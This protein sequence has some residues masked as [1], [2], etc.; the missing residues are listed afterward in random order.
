MDQLEQLYE[1]QLK[2]RLASFEKQRKAIKRLFLSAF[3]SFVLFVFV[4]PFLVAPNQVILWVFIIIG[5]LAALVFFGIGVVKF[6]TYRQQFKKGVVL[7]IVQLINPVYHYDSDNHI[8][9]SVFNE[10]RLFKKIPD[11]CFGDDFISGKIEK[12]DFEFSELK[13]AIKQVTTEDGKKSTNWKPIFEGLF[14]HADFNKQIEGT[15]YV[16]PD[17]VEK[18]FGKVGQKLQKSFGRGDLVKLENPA[19]E[20]EFKVYSTGQQEARYILTPTMMEAMINIKKKFNRKMHFSFTGERVYCAI[21]FSQGLFE[22][23]IFKSGIQFKDIEEMYHL[24]GLIETIVH[25]MNL[26]T[27]IWTKE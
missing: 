26:N 16:L 9:I 24:F 19:F 23:R 25:E 18:L 27:R 5:C 22:P 20:K 6:F 8:D 1:E 11:R 14:F 7:E 15:T 17:T 10:S 21:E 4:F 2:P 3:L 12:T 13:A